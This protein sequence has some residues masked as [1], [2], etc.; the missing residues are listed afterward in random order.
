MIE[1]VNLHDVSVANLTVAGGAPVAL[2]EAAA[3]AGLGKVGLLLRTATPKPLA[4]EVIG[5][6]DVVR[7]IKAACRAN[8]IRVFDV[9]AFILS[10]AA[11]IDTY[12]AALAT[13]AELGATH[14]SAVGTELLTNDAFLSAP[15][16]IELFGRLCDAAAEYGL[17]VGVEFM[18]YRDVRTLGETL[19]LLN[20]AG[21][22]NA[23]VILDV[24]HFHRSGARPEELDAVPAERIAYV[25]LC[26]AIERSP[27]LDG[28]AN[29]ARTARLHLGD[30]VIP[31]DA[32]LDRLPADA[33]LVIETPVAAD[34][35]LSDARKV[36]HCTDA[37]RRFFARRASQRG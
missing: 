29:E 36:A 20:A 1:E 27:S 18:L 16:R 25:Q 14:I 33:Q 5:R 2:I 8:D 26:D 17:H 15:E 34:A 37:A 4:H 19:E 7:E 11:D 31:L 9:E 21:R 22:A 3:A 13:G 23:G 35:D 12:R 30:G 10:P 24:L 28:L 6:P 32:I